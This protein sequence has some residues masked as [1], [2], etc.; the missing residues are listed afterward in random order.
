MFYIQGLE[1]SFKT[2]QILPGIYDEG[3]LIREKIKA[4]LERT[5]AG[6]KLGKWYYDLDGATDNRNEAEDFN[7]FRLP[8]VVTAKV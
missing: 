8:A 6:K 4:I 2:S 5:D 3:D 1:L 7:N